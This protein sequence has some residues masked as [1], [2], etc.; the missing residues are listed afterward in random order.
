MFFKEM[1]EIK[2]YKGLNFKT[3]LLACPFKSLYDR[4]KENRTHPRF[5]VFNSFMSIDH[6]SLSDRS[7]NTSEKIEV[8]NNA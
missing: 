8:L 7:L 3:V 5:K 6:L 4:Y 1:S 2:P